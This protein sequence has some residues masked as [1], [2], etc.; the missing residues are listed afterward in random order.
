MGKARTIAANE[1]RDPNKMGFDLN[2]QGDVALTS[3]PSMQTID[4]AKRGMDD[5]LE[6]YRN[7]LTNRLELSD[8]GRAQNLVKNQFLQEADRLV[9]AVWGCSQSISG[10]DGVDGRPYP[11]ARFLRYEREPAAGCCQRP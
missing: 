5:V 3:V 9:P 10:A 6:R 11:R 2:D 1:R 8:A 4:Y 7:P